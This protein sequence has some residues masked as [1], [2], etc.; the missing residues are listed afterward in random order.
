R[1]RRHGRGPHGGRAAQSAGGVRTDQ[2]G[3][4][5]ARGHP[6]GAL[7]RAHQLGDRRG[8]ELRGHHGGPRG[9]RRRTHR[10]GRPDRAPHLRRR[11]RRRDRCPAGP[12]GTVGPVQRH[13]RWAAAELGRARRRD[14]P[15]VRP[16][17]LR[18]DPR[19]HADLPRRPRGHR[20]AAPPLRAG[21]AEDPRQ[22]LP[23]AGAARLADHLRRRA[24]PRRGPDSQRWRHMTAQPV[25][26]P[27]ILV[28]WASE[29][30]TNRGVTALARGSRDLLQSVSPSAEI[31]ISKCGGRPAAG[32]GGWPGCLVRERAPWRLGM[33]DYFRGFDLV[34]DTRAGD[35][36]ADIYGLE[37]LITMSMVH[38]CARAA[39]AP[40]VM[41][42][43]TIGPFI[44]RRGRLLARW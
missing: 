35:S 37:R 23:A 27:R 30:A 16:G 36:F 34:W 4:G 19:E 6:A 5:P 40:I 42:P 2:G 43:Q 15:P 12:A 13:R 8:P 26:P 18:R 3:G 31:A 38:E 20:A 11:A 9:A 28:L 22:R 24:A 41:A 25:T 1:L 10:G 14:L 29:S 39:G 17:A 32:A 44:T 7:H 33:Q 21:P